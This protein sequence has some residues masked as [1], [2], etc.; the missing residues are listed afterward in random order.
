[1]IFKE[2]KMHHETKNLDLVGKALTVYCSSS[3]TVA[4]IYFEVARELGR[5]MAM[6]GATLVYGGTK[7]G[8]MGAISQAARE[9]GGRT[10]GVI[11]ARMQ[12]L[13]ITDEDVADLIIT[14]GMR[15]RKA[16]MEERAD[17]FI[18]L[19]G[20]FGTLEEFFEILT[21]KQIGL[22]N[23]PIVLININGYYDKLLE[24]IQVGNDQAFIKSSGLQLFHLANAA[25]PALEYIATYE[26]TEIESKWFGLPGDSEVRKLAEARNAQGEIPGSE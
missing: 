20:G 22:H 6:Y 8:L 14:N 26:P 18:A 4:P 25:Q 13:G 17:A 24:Q 2:L 3:A 16:I 9:A 5:L 21:A 7:V 1:M 19:P 23:K 12:L 11:P 10:I 15:E